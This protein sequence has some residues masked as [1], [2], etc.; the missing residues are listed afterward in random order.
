VPA[1]RKVA[2][3]TGLD[4]DPSGLGFLSVNAD[5]PFGSP[6]FINAVPEGSRLAD[7]LRGVDDDLVEF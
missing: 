1:A 3:L 2:F 7:S 5:A 4:G 6:A